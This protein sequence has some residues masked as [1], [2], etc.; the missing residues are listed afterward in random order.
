MTFTYSGGKGNSVIIPSDASELEKRQASKRS[1]RNDLLA[2]CD[3]IVTA[4]KENDE[5]VPVAWKTY[6]QELRD[7]DFSDPTNLTW[8]TEPT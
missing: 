7:M 1:F 6:R 8:P 4:A 3:Y 5:Q 2:K